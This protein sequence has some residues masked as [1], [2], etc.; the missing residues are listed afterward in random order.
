MVGLRRDTASL[1]A[2]QYYGLYDDKCSCIK[3]LANS[4][5]SKSR[6]YFLLRRNK[7]IPTTVC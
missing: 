4:S 1:A 6:G 7:P 3:G 2:A 5:D